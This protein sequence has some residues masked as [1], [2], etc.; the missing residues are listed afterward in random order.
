MSTSESAALP[1][2]GKGQ[3]TGKRG[4]AFLR[5]GTFVFHLPLVYLGGNLGLTK[6]GL[7][8]DLA[9]S[10]GQRF[11]A[12]SLEWVLQRIECF[13]AGRELDRLLA[14]SA[15]HYGFRDVRALMG[16]SL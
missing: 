5:E 4:G 14:A 2:H 10:S 7:W 12:H 16:R 15:V 3:F 11:V 13:R 6:D 8:I 1:A 9:D